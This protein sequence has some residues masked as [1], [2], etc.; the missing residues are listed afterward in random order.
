MDKPQKFSNSKEVIAFLAET[1]PASFSLTGD[2]KP[3]KIGIFQDIVEQL[4]DEERL[5]KT[6]LRSTLRHYTNSWRYLH[7]VKEGAFRVDLDGSHNAAIEK[8]H[9]DHAQ[10]QLQ[11]SKA[12]VAEKRKEQSKEQSAK[13]EPAKKTYKNKAS[14][15]S[16]NTINGTNLDKPKPNKKPPPP[17]KLTDEHLKVGTL[18]TVKV[19][20]EPMPATITDVSKDGVQV[21][22][23]TGMVVKVQVDNLRLVRSKR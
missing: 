1:F 22:L 7:S 15:T 2:A 12:K 5:S 17:E 8:E 11:E 3:L 6:L 16:K 14:S 13:K 19:G 21:Q 10:L 4:K 23:D 18:V 9:V 20:K